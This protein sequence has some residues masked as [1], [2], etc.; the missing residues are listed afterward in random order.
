MWSDGYV[1]GCLRKGILFVWLLLGSNCCLLLTVV[2]IIAILES[3][4]NVPKWQ[5]LLLSIVILII[6]IS[7][8]LLRT[9][10]LKNQRVLK[11]RIVL[12]GHWTMRNLMRVHRC[13][14]YGRHNWGRRIRFTICAIGT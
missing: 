9:T 5:S 6:K 7:V 1:E 14:Y 10:L 13:L 11:E 2:S 12:N 8:V 3:L 4:K